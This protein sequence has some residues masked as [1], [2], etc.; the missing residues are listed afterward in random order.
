MDQPKA[1]PGAAGRAKREADTRFKYEA[2][3]GRLFGQLE[4]LAVR[5]EPF[6]S[7]GRVLWVAECICSCG[8]RAKVLAQNLPVGT[9][10]SCGCLAKESS[11]RNILKALER[12]RVVRPE[13][14]R[15]KW[16]SLVGQSF[17]RLTVELI[18]KRLMAGRM[19]WAGVCRC[20]CGVM[21]RA[22]R[23][24]DLQSGRAT[25]CG[26][27]QIEN[28][29]RVVRR[30]SMVKVSNL[31][32]KTFGRLTLQRIY[33]TETGIEALC[34]CSCGKPRTARL[35][36]I[37]CGNVS[38]C[39][40]ARIESIIR[41]G[42]V[43]AQNRIENAGMR[44]HQFVGK[45]FGRLTVL[46][47][48]HVFD[49]LYYWR[50]ICTCECGNAVETAA[51]DLVAGRVTSCGCFKSEATKMRHAKFREARGRGT[52]VHRVWRQSVVP[53]GRWNALRDRVIA[54]DEA[55]CL[56]CG[57]AIYLQVHHIVPVTVDHER[58]LDI[59]N[60]ATLCKAC[61]IEKAHGGRKD[62]WVAPETA[63]LLESIVSA[64]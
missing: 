35:Y 64:L 63:R 41:K 21:N 56:L 48:K 61:H 10:R 34:L 55:R 15:V 40:C 52:L 25:S 39:G 19:L 31:E 2:W 44:W 20:S 51:A 49:G 18:E 62:G 37:R 17:G 22:I 33:R 12:A 38:S 11:Q 57:G 54:R 60:L 30:N 50:A 58:A 28:R 1:T 9:V 29:V 26:C 3:I 7:S 59:A 43:A 53:Q 14:A 6:G 47:V 46:R 8:T 24:T 4:V 27:L 5:R 32:G 42:K 36:D 45:K 23:A 13:L 16:S